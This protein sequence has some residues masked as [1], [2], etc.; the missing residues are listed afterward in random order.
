MRLSN[1]PRKKQLPSREYDAS[2]NGVCRLCTAGCGLTL[3][4]SGGAPVD[5]F[6][7]ELH[8]VNK[9]AL[10]PR[11][12]AL[13]RQIYG[14][15]RLSAPAIRESADAPWRPADWDTALDFTARRMADTGGERLVIAG[16]ESDPFDFLCGADWAA[17]ALGC[18]YRPGRF[19]APAF[20]RSASLFRMIG[21]C[22]DQL[23]SNTPRDWCASRGILVVGGDLAAENPVTFGP[24]QDARDRGC[25]LLYLGARG[26]MTSRRATG[27]WIVRPGTESLALSALLHILLRDNA[28]HQEFVSECVSGLDALRER[29]APY[30]PA[31]VAPHCGLAQERL[32]ELAAL[33]ERLSPIQ[34]IMGQLEQRRWIDDAL[35]ALCLALA[36]LKGC[37]GR[38][39]GG[40]NILG[41]TPFAWPLTDNPPANDARAEGGKAAPAV[42]EPASP[43]PAVSEPPRADDPTDHT[44]SKNGPLLKRDHP[45]A[46]EACIKAHPDGAFIGFGDPLRRLAGQSARDG[47]RRMAFVVHMGPFD[48]ATR[49]LAHVSLP[50]AHWMEYA[51]LAHRSDG[52]AIQWAPPLLPPCGFALPPL[53]IW[54][55][56]M[57][58]LRPESLPPWAACP[59]DAASPRRL[60]G[61]TLE[62]CP[63]TAGLCVDDLE[64]ARNDASPGGVL[65][66]CPRGAGETGRDY[67]ISR[68]I[69]GNVRGRN[70]I[71]FTPG[72]LWPESGRRFPTENGRIRLEE[73]S[74]PLLPEA[75]PGDGLT[76]VVSGLADRAADHPQEPL[77]PRENLGDAARLHRDTAAKL[78][79]EH[80]CAITLSSAAGE[81]DVQAV[82]A[83]DVPENV[84]VLPPET[85]LALVAGEEPVLR[86]AAVRAARRK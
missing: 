54:A 59:E 34:I 13:Y 33:I 50:A 9:G 8:P 46:L 80:G 21:I 68:Y 49:R 81:V 23:L 24:L 36:A 43:S 3:F 57:R 86:P 14:K 73:V 11:A 41:A 22:G 35:P 66:P 39:G 47:L 30:A 53:D 62:N 74:L 10:C 32:E 25:E 84:V 31:R 72:S 15:S 60:A 76:L 37:I 45:L 4:S 64:R 65:W 2:E 20:G 1:R 42:T 38:P 12:L 78:G 69:R 82:I 79:I 17:E 26:G 7:T 6:G 63:L 58:R 83:P 77:W 55:G 75:P 48:N 61:W 56:L 71:L 40:L 51:C 29:L 44:E 19:F 16:H 85:G 28:V 70:N 27:A 67:E 18:A 5:L 52:R